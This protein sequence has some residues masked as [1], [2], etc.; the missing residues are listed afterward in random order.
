MKP[1]IVVSL[2]AAVLVALLIG[3]WL[4][5]EPPHDARGAPSSPGIGA[6]RPPVRHPVPDVPLAEEDGSDPSGDPTRSALDA[7]FPALGRIRCGAGG[8]PAHAD[9]QGPASVLPI[10]DVRGATLIAAVTKAEGGSVIESANSAD[11][12]HLRWSGAEPGRW[13][14]CVATPPQTVEVHGTLRWPDG[15]PGAGEQL[16]GCPGDVLR[17]DEEGHFTFAIAVGQV[18]WPTGFVQDDDGAFGRGKPVEVE[19][20]E[21]GPQPDIVVVLPGEDQMMSRQRQTELL[22]RLADMLLDGAEGLPDPAADAL[23]H[24]NTPE[25]AQVLREWSE[26]TQARKQRRIDDMEPFLDPDADDV[27]LRDAL[28]FGVGR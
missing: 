7:A 24:A 15:E 1:R 21:P 20:T 13:G 23:P 4:R 28:L 27:E 25:S 3:W 6:D 16:T 14:T 5:F 10:I 8:M 2:I 11:R 18:C 19:P 17:A 26:R 22:A 9:P 12:V